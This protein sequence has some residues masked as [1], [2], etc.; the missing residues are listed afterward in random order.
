MDFVSA[1]RR[2]SMDWRKQV[3]GLV[4]GRAPLVVL[5]AFVKGLVIE[6]TIDFRIPLPAPLF[7]GRSRIGPPLSPL[8]NPPPESPAG[9][10]NVTS[11]PA[12]I[13]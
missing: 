12:C 3:T 5:A 11:Q 13:E 7:A 9:Q 8:S 10:Y 2:L 1:H 4:F 6:Q